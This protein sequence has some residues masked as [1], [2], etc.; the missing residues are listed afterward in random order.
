MDRLLF[1]GKTDDEYC[2]SA[3]DYCRNHFTAI[4]FFGEWG[5]PFPDYAYNW[6]GDYIISY[7]SRW[8]VP[9][10]I[11]AN[12]SKAALNFHPAPPEY[13]GYGPVNWAL[14]DGVS[15]YGVTC[16]HMAN[17]VDSGPII[18]VLRFGVFPDDTVSKLLARTHVWQIELFDQVMGGIVAGGELPEADEQ[19]GGKTHTRR[20]LDE[21]ATL[22]PAM[23]EA[24]ILRRIRATTY[25]RWTPNLRVNGDRYRL[26]KNGN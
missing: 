9:P 24:E 15:E 12:A 4:G 17:R 18:K 21:L 20:E 10:A 5:D 26:V 19:W 25:D 23:D 14:Y 8:I 22:T 6:R 13:P 2:S 1:L 7:L 3:F 11:L 16:H